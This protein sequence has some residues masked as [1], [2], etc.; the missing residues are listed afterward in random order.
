M[1][2]RYFASVEMAEK[3]SPRFGTGSKKKRGLSSKKKASSDSQRRD[4]PLLDRQTASNGIQNDEVRY[5]VVR[6]DQWVKS[7]F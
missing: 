6:I 3:S 2:A 5:F 4:S 7:K 1:A